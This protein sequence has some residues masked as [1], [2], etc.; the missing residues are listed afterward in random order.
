MVAYRIT[1]KGQITI[2]KDI[3]DHLRVKS[4]DSV[5]IFAHPNGTAVILPVRPI[6]ALKGI[7]KSP[8][9]RPVTLK[10]MDEAIAEGAIASMG[11]DF[12]PGRPARPTRV[13]KRS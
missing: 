8:W 6:T 13:A 4:G 1:S 11:A 12:R 2:P 9:K 10:E 5:K 7:L 3:R